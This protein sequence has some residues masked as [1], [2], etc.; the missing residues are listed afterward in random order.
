MDVTDFPS[1]VVR[2]SSRI[3]PHVRRTPVDRARWL[4]RRIG[5]RVFLK[6]ENLQA[7]GSFKLRGATNRVLAAAE[8]R[9][10]AEVVAAS[11]GNHGA[12]VALACR[13]AGLPCRVFVPE[14]ASPGK[15]EAIRDLGAELVTAGDDGVIAERSA[16]RYAEENGLTYVS[17]YNDPVVIAG[18]GTVGA[19]LAEQCEDLDAVFIS[20]GGGGLLSGVAGFLCALNP[21][22]EVVACSARLSSVMYQSLR[23][24]EVV[25]VP[26][27]PTLSDGTAGGVEAGAITLP[28]CRD[29][30]DRHELVSED[31]IARAL[32]D[33]IERQ[34]ILVEGAAALALAGLVRSGERYRDARVAVILCG[35]NIT[36][37]TLGRALARAAGARST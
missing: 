33:L 25:D 19:E 29:L 13:R 26:S 9:P 12:G 37:E 5:A 34:H 4:E 30:I 16:R 7:T 35:A 23:R 3:S 31:E 17:P 14:G 2:A 8:E 20:L 36:A 24:G 21:S 27:D 28:L 11:T 15:L 18:Q 22:I 32:S 10:G 6:Q 1:V